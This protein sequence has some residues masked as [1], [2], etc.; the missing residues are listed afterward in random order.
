MTAKNQNA[1]NPKEARGRTAKTTK[2]VN[3]RRPSKVVQDVPPPTTPGR[4]SRG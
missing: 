2:V 3:E 4:G 1:K